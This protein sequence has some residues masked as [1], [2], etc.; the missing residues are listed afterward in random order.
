MVRFG[1]L[2]SFTSNEVQPTPTPLPHSQ[3]SAAFD[4][5]GAR[6]LLLN[7]LSVQ[8]DCQLVF[9][10]TEQMRADAAP[11]SLGPA[12]DINNLMSH[13]PCQPNELFSRTVGLENGG[14]LQAAWLGTYAGA[15]THLHLVLSLAD[16][17]VTGVV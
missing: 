16:L 7:H 6:G 9:D 15:S 14:K 10:S 13:L 11:H 5:G 3:T 4:E 1:L 12:I 8:Q 17:P 2:L